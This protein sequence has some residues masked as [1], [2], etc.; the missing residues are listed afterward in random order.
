[1]ISLVIPVFN[2]KGP[3][4][5]MIENV[6]SQTISDW[7]L[8]LVDDGSD[9]DTLEM[10]LD[11]SVKYN[12]IHIVKRER[13]PKG[14]PTC[15]NIGLEL[16]KGEFIIFL[17]SDDLISSNCLKNRLEFIESNTEIDFAVFRARSFHDIEDLKNKKIIKADYSYELLGKPENCF[18]DLLGGKYPL[19]VYT[20]IYRRKKLIDSDIRWDE[21]LRV[22]QDID[23]NF[24]TLSKGLRC[25]YDKKSEY[26]YFIRACHNQNSI[27]SNLATNE[28]YLSAKY[29]IK[30]TNENLDLLPN[31]KK[32]KKEFFGFVIFYFNKIIIDKEKT[33]DYLNYCL[34]Y[35]S[36]QRILRLRMVFYFT[37]IFRDS[38]Y[39]RRALRI[40]HILFFPE[41]ELKK[42]II[43]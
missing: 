9:Q 25:D 15:R 18:L 16:A 20:N 4:E 24:T 12:N 38:K 1:M 6:V 32:Y 27:S 43:R 22:L 31:S 41:I 10:I 19:V 17:D 3:L 5:E 33:N 11:Y 23:F 28:K 36:S 39:F 2:N 7:E 13:L 29:L 34:K 42:L 14:A 21:N 37:N 35:F 40:F 8:I 30:K 26:D